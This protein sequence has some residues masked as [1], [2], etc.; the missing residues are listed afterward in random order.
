[1]P[2]PRSPSLGLR[3]TAASSRG[4]QAGVAA[5]AVVVNR[6]GCGRELAVGGWMASA[7]GNAI[8]GYMHPGSGRK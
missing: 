4:S 5:A 2:S 8:D 1:M 7:S 6:C 3:V